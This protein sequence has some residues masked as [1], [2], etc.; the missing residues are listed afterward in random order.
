MLI[1][2]LRDAQRKP[3]ATIVATS[4][5]NV[6]VAIGHNRWPYNKQLMT[7][8]AKGRAEI[9]GN[10]LED[11]P[12]VPVR[13]IDMVGGL[14]SIDEAIEM[15]LDDLLDRAKKYFKEEVGEQMK[16]TLGYKMGEYLTS[17]SEKLK[18]LEAFNSQFPLLK[19]EKNNV[20]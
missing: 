16:T 15:E 14:F 4:A 12:S 18:K 9:Y 10:G 8:I 13:I 6:G 3:Y 1:K 11:L 2:H 20:T 7:E 5:T 19:K 17:L